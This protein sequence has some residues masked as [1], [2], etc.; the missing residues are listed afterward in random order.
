MPGTALNPAG[1][2]NAVV[3]VDALK[4]LIASGP[5]QPVAQKDLPYPHPPK[6]H[7]A[8][9][10]KTQITQDNVSGMLADLR[11]KRREKHN[12]ATVTIDVNGTQ[13]TLHFTRYVN[14]DGTKGGFIGDG[15][16]V[17][18]KNTYI[19]AT[20]VV[21]G[22]FELQ[23]AKIADG[24]AL[25]S[26][27]KEGQYAHGDKNLV[28]DSSIGSN[29]TLKTVGI[30]GVIQVRTSVVEDNASIDAGAGRTYIYNSTVR[31]GMH[32]KLTA[33]DPKELEILYIWESTVGKNTLIEFDKE[34]PRLGII[35]KNVPDNSKITIDMKDYW[36]PVDQNGKMP[37][38]TTVAYTIIMPGLNDKLLSQHLDDLETSAHSNP[39]SAYAKAEIASLAGNN[40][41][42]LENVVG[43]AR[44][45]Y[46]SMHYSMKHAENY[47]GDKSTIPL[48]Y[49]FHEGVCFEHALMLYEVLEREYLRGNTNV[50][51]R[52]VSGAADSNDSESLHAWVEVEINNSVYVVDPT[53]PLPF[54]IAGKR[55]NGN[56]IRESAPTNYDYVVDGEPI[57]K[58][59]QQA[60][61]PLLRVANR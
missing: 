54:M 6:E 15:V 7:Q 35:N 58:T 31:S 17:L 56:F 22:T 2:Q 44:A 25:V 41:A 37:N 4:I 40:A 49:F 27:G 9:E 50:K 18:D 30:N 29:A 3:M 16:K 42:E 55:E 20:A 60:L 36:F 34:P 46:K 38:I 33:A 19:A 51:P 10:N 21:Y 43:L 13:K 14:P 48:S 28:Y 45:V 61:K 8:T 59:E 1:G 23:N 57:V 32:T 24:A 26:F 39:L 12:S 11:S 52:F 5:N 53:N 47:P